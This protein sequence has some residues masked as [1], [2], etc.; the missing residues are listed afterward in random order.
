VIIVAIA[1]E[2]RDSIMLCEST[3]K[4]SK[5]QKVS[6]LSNVIWP[7]IKPYNYKRYMMVP[8]KIQ[9]GLGLI[10]LDIIVL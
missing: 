1:N 9:A 10:F 6:I 3:H 5:K 7:K 8:R 2:K 4:F